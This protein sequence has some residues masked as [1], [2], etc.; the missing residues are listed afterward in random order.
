MSGAHE[1]IRD[2][3]EERGIEAV[4]GREVCQE[5]ERHACREQKPF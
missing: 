3:G 1:E 2:E 5:G 4:D